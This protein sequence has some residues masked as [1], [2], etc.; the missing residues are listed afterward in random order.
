MG[1]AIQ[2]LDYKVTPEDRDKI[3]IEFKNLTVAFADA[4]I[5]LTEF[6]CVERSSVKD[7][8][9]IVNRV[10]SAQGLIEKGTKFL[11]LVE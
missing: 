7:S 8:N 1:I 2:Y 5:D 3:L 11:K 10:S 4:N 9:D 6:Y